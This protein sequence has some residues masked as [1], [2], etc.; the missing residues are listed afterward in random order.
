MANVEGLEQEAERLA[1]VLV[2]LDDQNSHREMMPETWMRR[3]QQIKNRHA[4]SS[5]SHRRC[6]SRMPQTL[7]DYVST[8]KGRSVA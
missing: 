8:G 1:G 4:A 6:R 3:A 7:E 2:A 5:V